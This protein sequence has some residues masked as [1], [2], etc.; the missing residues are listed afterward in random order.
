MM[1]DVRYSIITLEILQQSFFIFG[2]VRLTGK[3]FHAIVP[4]YCTQ[5]GYLVHGQCKCRQIFAFTDKT[6]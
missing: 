6:G 3:I 2:D 1:L 4:M 5:L